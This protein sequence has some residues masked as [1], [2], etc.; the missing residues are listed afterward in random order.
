M[1][2]AINQYLVQVIE[3]GTDAPGCQQQSGDGGME[4]GDTE[5]ESMNTVS[6]H[7]TDVI[8][9]LLETMVIL[10]EGNRKRFDKVVS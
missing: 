8:C 9:G 7:D 4:N 5:N 3:H 2:L 6:I 10:W 1:I